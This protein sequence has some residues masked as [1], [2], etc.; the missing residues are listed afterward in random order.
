MNDPY[1]SPGEMEQDIVIK[2]HRDWGELCKVTFWVSFMIALAAC[3]I[4]IVGIPVFMYMF[5]SNKADFCY[6][7]P[8]QYTQRNPNDTFEV[9]GKWVTGYTLKQ[10]IP[11]HSDRTLV[12][13][14]PTTDGVRLEAEKF[15]CPIR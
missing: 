13:D 9:T 1:R 5:S 6:V 10:H 11:W 2:K 8:I 12:S 15:G 7:E 3:V 4:S 14:I